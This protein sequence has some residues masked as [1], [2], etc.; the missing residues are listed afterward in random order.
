M[1]SGTSRGREHYVF[2]Q[3]CATPL[4]ISCRTAYSAH[5]EQRIAHDTSN[6]SGLRRVLDDR[7]TTQHWLAKKLGVSDSKVSYWCRGERPIAP[8]MIPVI[9]ELLKV[10]QKDIR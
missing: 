8:D 10:R 3:I 9:A 6:T 7:G 5:M 1:N 2:V 4:A